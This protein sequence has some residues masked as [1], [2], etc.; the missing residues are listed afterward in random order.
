MSK[1]TDAKQRPDPARKGADPLR[2]GEETN[3]LPVAR[4]GPSRHVVYPTLRV[5]A[6]RD[7]LR[8]VSLRPGDDLVIGRDEAAALVLVDP[9][10]SRRHARVTCDPSGAIA[11]E[12]LGSTNGT[13]VNGQ[14]VRRAQLRPG[15]QLEIGMVSMRLEMLGPDELAHLG[16]VLARLDATNRD[17]LTGLLTRAGLEEELEAITRRAAE[18]GSEAT[19]ILVDVDHFKHVNDT[20]GHLVGD[21]ALRAI[22]R[23]VLLGIREGDPAYRYGG[24]ELLILLDGCTERAGL[25]VAER[26]RRSVANYD[27]PRTTPGH[28]VTASLGVGTLIPGET[29]REWF[30]RLDRALYE[31]KS[32]G[33][34]R[35][36]AA[37]P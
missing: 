21:E 19:A 6:G 22:A 29:W 26:I 30:A 5:V 13:A 15:D 27:W 32:G 3:K 23:L 24:E 37:R 35:V 16:S 7:L 11:I 12:D 10:V 36:V 18:R 25:E 2:I 17:P 33:R 8:F 1:P 20:F 31:A 4:G 9:S 14:P 28:R 34:N